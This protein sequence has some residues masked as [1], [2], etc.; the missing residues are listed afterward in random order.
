MKFFFR[1]CYLS[2][3][4]LSNNINKFCDELEKK[5]G[6]DKRKF[7]NGDVPITFFKSFSWKKLTIF[8]ICI[9]AKV[10]SYMYQEFVSFVKKFNNTN[11]LI[12][13]FLF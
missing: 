8:I 2:T 5:F 9:I 13:N 10:S 12:E 6:Y 7:T 1:I 3:F 11:Y 4:F